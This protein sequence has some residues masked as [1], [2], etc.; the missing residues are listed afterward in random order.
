M[1]MRGS[2]RFSDAHIGLVLPLIEF[3]TPSISARQRDAKRFILGAR[4][5]RSWHRLIKAH[6]WSAWATTA[7]LD[8]PHAINQ[9]RR[10]ATHASSP[11]QT[12][13]TLPEHAA[14]TQRRVGFATA[15][16]H[17]TPHAVCFFKITTTID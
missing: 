6:C 1:P 10:A 9:Q 15:I 3:L 11:R 2:D 12:E 4:G 13:A 8:S 16:S 5:C 17:A 14:V 7:K